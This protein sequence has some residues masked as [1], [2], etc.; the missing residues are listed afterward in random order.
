[1]GDGGLRAV[2]FD[3][4]GTILNSEGL[5][6]LATGLILERLG[7][8]GIDAWEIHDRWDDLLLELWHSGSFLP[9]AEMFKLTL[10]LALKDFGIEVGSGELY[11]ALRLL[12]EVFED[13]ARPYR[14]VK[15]V[16]AF[17][18][19]LGL[20]VGV[21]SDADS[22]ML[23]SLLSKHGL[24]GYLDFI[25]IS[26]EVGALKPSEKIFEVALSEAGCE[27]GEALMV[28]DSARD[29]E[30]AKRAGLMAV[31]LARGESLELRGRASGVLLEPDMVISNLEEL[32]GP[33]LSLVGRAN[34][35]SRALWPLRR[36]C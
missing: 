24:T 30:G 14:E 17:C 4:F 7:L 35:A 32:K 1:L 12:V 22:G 9:T 23:R 19:D 5:H 6:A 3:A 15:D 33:I 21:V 2:F 13:G 31:L 10:G 25:I 11:E 26:D 27:A 28:G 36:V 29:I 34:P 20:K 16:L 8:E 18:R